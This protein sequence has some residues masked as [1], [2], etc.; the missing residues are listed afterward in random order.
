LGF[1]PGTVERPCA[2]SGEQLAG[3]RSTARRR[4][5]TGP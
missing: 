1:L 5:Y 3:W 2:T 4:R